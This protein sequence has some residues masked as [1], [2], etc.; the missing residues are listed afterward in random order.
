[1]SVGNS[2]AGIAACVK[3]P[4]GPQKKKPGAL[5][6]ARAACAR[7]WSGVRPESC[8]MFAMLNYRVVRN[9]SMSRRDDAVEPVNADELVCW[10]TTK[11]RTSQTAGL[12][13]RVSQT[14]RHAEPAR[15]Q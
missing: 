4:N 7:Y 5:P 1:M 14:R 2:C 8:W 9:E 11:S 15:E 12:N 13:L 3:A 10:S 6:I